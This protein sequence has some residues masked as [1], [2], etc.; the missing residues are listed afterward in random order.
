[1]IALSHSRLIRHLPL[2]RT[3]IAESRIFRMPCRHYLCAVIIEPQLR[4][5]RGLVLYPDYR[6]T[7]VPVAF[8][9]KVC[10][11]VVALMATHMLTP[12]ARACT[13]VCGL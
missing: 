8:V 4:M 2:S 11:V 1:M 12:D 6:V 13:R 3:A 7:T 9:T 10:C 5:L